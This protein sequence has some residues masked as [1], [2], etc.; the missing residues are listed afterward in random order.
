MNPFDMA[1]ILIALGVHSALLT[2]LLP[3]SELSSDATQTNIQEKLTACKRKSRDL[4]LRVS[5]IAAVRK[6]R[7]R[8]YDQRSGP[9]KRNF[10]S[11]AQ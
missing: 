7:H 4:M 6:P 5:K 10:A 2:D 3:A 11:K 1:S 9:R 8:V